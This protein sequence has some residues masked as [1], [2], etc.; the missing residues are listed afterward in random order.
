MN[1][2]LHKIQNGFCFSRQLLGNVVDLDSL[3]RILSNMGFKAFLALFD[4]GN[5]FPSVGHEWLHEVLRAK[6]FPIGLR[7][8]VKQLYFM[9]A[10]YGTAGCKLMFLWYV[11]C[12]VLQG[13]PLS[14]MLFAVIMDPFCIGFGKLEARLN[15]EHHIPR[16]CVRACADDVGAVIASI[17]HLKG[18]K[19]VFDAACDL[20]NLK[21]KR[22]KCVLIPVFAAFSSKLKE[23]VK[24]WLA[25]FMPCWSDFDVR[26]AA[27]YLGFHVGPAAG[28]YQ[29][30]AVSS[31]WI[32]RTRAIAQ[33]GTSNAV[34]MTA[35]NSY[36]H[37]VWGFKCQLLHVPDSILKMESPL[38]HSILRMPFCALGPAGPFFL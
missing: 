11:F 21:L 20:A 8:L 7:Y 14:G 26:D 36:A 37:S 35:Y 27:E 16:A 22:P 34:A 1:C 18:L 38:L 10:C 4:F 33:V 31:K 24:L 19:V 25:S 23:Q 17:K 5:A 32:A 2:V 9:S 29:L 30:Q 13:C 6:G 12:G 15:R 28:C 3:A